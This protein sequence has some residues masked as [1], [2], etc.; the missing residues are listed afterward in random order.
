MK[1]TVRHLD[2]D[3]ATESGIEEYVLQTKYVPREGDSII[4]PKHIYSY[5][6]EVERVIWDLSNTQHEID[7]VVEASS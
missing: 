4:M 7:V 6:C 1:V 3:F 5:P 2:N